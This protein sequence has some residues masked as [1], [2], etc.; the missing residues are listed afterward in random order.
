[1][2][3]YSIVLGRIHGIDID[4]TATSHIG[5]PPMRFQRIVFIALTLCTIVVSL[6]LGRSAQR[7]P[8]T[9]LHTATAK[10]DV[11]AVGRLLSQG[12]KVN[13]VADRAVEKNFVRMTPLHVATEAGKL[14]VAKLLVSRGANVNARTNFG[15]TPLQLA[16]SLKDPSL[17]LF[18]LSKGAIANTK[19]NGNRTPLQAAASSGDVSLVRAL[20]SNGANVN[21]M[22]NFGDSPLHL[23]AN[24]QVAQV[25]LNTG[26][27]VNAKS[28]W[29]LTPLEKAFGRGPEAGNYRADVARL[30]IE[31]GARIP[32]VDA[33]SSYDI[34]ILRLL[35]NKGVLING[36]NN[37]GETALTVVASYDDTPLPD[38]LA[39]LAYGSSEGAKAMQRKRME[40]ARFLL[41]AGAD[42]EARDLEG[43]TPLL[44]AA[45]HGRAEMTELLLS[46]GAKH[47]IKDKHGY[48]PL[49]WAAFNNQ[50]AAVRVLLNHGADVKSKNKEGRTPLDLARSGA[51][52]AADQVGIKEIIQSLQQASRGPHH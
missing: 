33:I 13:T 16:A 24:A 3:R 37:E 28:A 17:A 29:G 5:V 32:L 26:A 9:P 18:L 47:G 36:R 44:R 43:G 50:P 31:R 51:K 19:D 21:L 40:V 22:S 2:R 12:S 48:T 6:P 49:H 15:Q 4:T 35:L 1:M 25:L 30:L 7:Y 34:G 52:D 39:E 8:W 38:N 20:I 42:I 45:Q 46:R 11:A 10:G 41:Q 27:K 14:E 23:A